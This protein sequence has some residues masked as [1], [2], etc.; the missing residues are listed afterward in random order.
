MRTR[1][2]RFQNRYRISGILTSRSEI[3][4]G[5]GDTGEFLT[6]ASA[7]KLP[8]PD[9]VV[10]ADPEFATT[11]TA[12]DNKPIVPG[13][14]IKGILRQWLDRSGIDGKLTDRV[15][16]TIAGGGIAVFHDAS[17]TG[18]SHDIAAGF[19]WY[20][21]KRKTCLMPQV[22]I[23][24]AT[25]TAAEGLLYYTEFV[26]P[27]ASFQLEIAGQDWTAE[28][29]DLLLFALAR[30]FSD[31]AQPARIGAN[32]AGG[33]GEVRWALGK[34]EIMGPEEQKKWLA[35]PVGPYSQAFNTLADPAGVEKAAC[36]KWNP[37]AAPERVSI[38]VELSFQGPFLINDPS[39]VRSR[40]ETNPD[41][42]AHAI[43]KTTDG[44]YCLPQSSIRGVLRAQARRIF[45]TLCWQ[46]PADLN[47]LPKSGAEVRR[48]DGLPDL[49][50]FYRM[51]GATGWRSPIEIDDFAA[52]APVAAHKQEFVAIDRFTGG[53]SDER[54]FNAHGLYAPRFGGEIRIEVD[55]WRDAGLDGGAWLL[56]AF[57]L[58]DWIEGDITVGFGAAKGYGACRAVIQVRGDSKEAR[59]LAGIVNRD[60]VSLANDSLL[61]R[62]ELDWKQFTQ[63]QEAA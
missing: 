31:T 43:I 16:G 47:K 22:V 28:D 41:P 15:F 30:A 7:L 34:I 54:K 13:S 59:L 39:Q 55:R 12:F 20:D 27:G 44:K 60:P 9:D 21:P 6:R 26:P 11:A 62:W 63:S 56:L 10:A 32:E 45:Q 3:H 53:A 29:R 49:S 38:G 37:A 23:D 40:D 36:A 5:D 58:H 17:W 4:V 14:S 18:G 33:W 1:D 42:I 8:V 50:P 46:S 61:E 2:Y 24:P 19:R 48:R 25:R 52:L 57:V 51:F 35:G